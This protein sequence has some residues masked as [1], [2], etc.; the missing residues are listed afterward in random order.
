MKRTRSALFLKKM[1]LIALIS[2]FVGNVERRTLALTRVDAVFSLTLIRDPQ[3]SDIYGSISGNLE[4]TKALVGVLHCGEGGWRR[5]L[6]RCWLEVK[7]ISPL[8]S[9]MF[10]MAKMSAKTTTRLEDVMMAF[11]LL[12][13]GK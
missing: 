5:N 8:P 6:V 9:S 12:F 7:P 1:R 13:Y 2:I 4:L 11:L 10:L 3:P